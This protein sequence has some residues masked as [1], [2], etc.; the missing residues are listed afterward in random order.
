[1]QDYPTTTYQKEMEIWLARP[2][3]TASSPSWIDQV[4]KV[5]VSTGSFK[6]RITA[7]PGTYRLHFYKR[8][9][10]LAG[11]VAVSEL[12]TVEPGKVL[13]ALPHNLGPAEPNRD[14]LAGRRPGVRDRSTMT[15]T[16]K[17]DKIAGYPTVWLQIC[18]PDGSSAAGA[19]PAPNS[20]SY[21]WTIGETAENSL[22]VSVYT[23]D[24]KFKGMSGTFKV[25][26]PA[27]LGAAIG[28][29]SRPRRLG[30]RAS[31]SGRCSHRPTSCGLHGTPPCLGLMW[32]SRAAR[33]SSCPPTA[34]TARPAVA[35][36]IETGSRLLYVAARRAGSFLILRAPRQ[37]QAHSAGADHIET[38]S[39]LVYVGPARR[40][41]FFLSSEHH[42]NGSALGGRAPHRDR[43]PSCLCGGR[44]AAP[45]LLI[46]RAPRQRKHA[47]RPPSTTSGSRGSQVSNGRPFDK[48]YRPA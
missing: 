25:K 39:R 42:G 12:F 35:P 4:G 2:S 46:L 11:S 16:W 34:T 14:P 30:L 33:A 13:A 9:A 22:R 23:P 3:S 21:Q 20:G 32:G 27:A 37:R 38:G 28:A 41:G 24:N 44:R 48:W 26:V 10:P 1:M 18:W 47:R 45:A 17:K 36:R 29:G 5:D 19:Y 40:A 8:A 7:V 31:C 15:I 43:V 6:W